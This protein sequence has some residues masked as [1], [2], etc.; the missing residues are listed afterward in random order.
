MASESGGKHGLGF[1]LKGSVSYQQVEKGCLHRVTPVFEKN[2]GNPKPPP[3]SEPLS[4]RQA[5]EAWE[6]SDSKLTQ[7][8]TAV[9]VPGHARVTLCPALKI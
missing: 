4:H 7:H 6:E 3:I 2:P 8:R 5:W 1:A 9:K